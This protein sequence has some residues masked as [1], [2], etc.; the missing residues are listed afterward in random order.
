MGVAAEYPIA[1]GIVKTVT[2]NV[3]TFVQ[4]RIAGNISVTSKSL[5]LK[6]GMHDED[7]SIP[8]PYQP[9]QTLVLFHLSPSLRYLV[10]EMYGADGLPIA[11][12][13]LGSANPLC[14]V[15]FDGIV[16]QSPALECTLSPVW[17]HTFYLPV[18]MPDDRIQDNDE[19]LAAEMKS[20]GFLEIEVWHM[21]SVPTEFLG[22]DKI[23]LHQIRRYGE[24]AEKALCQS[25]VFTAQ[26]LNAEGD[27]EEAEVDMGIHPK[28]VEKRKTKVFEAK[29]R[30]LEGSWLQSVTKATISFQCYFLDDFKDTFVY[31]EQD[32]TKTGADCFNSCYKKW[33]NL[34][35]QFI[36]AYSDWFPDTLKTRRFLCNYQDASGDSLP[37]PTLISPL[38]LP[39]SLATPNRVAHWI[40]CTEFSV[41]PRQRSCAEIGTWQRPQDVLALRRGSVQ[42]HAVLLCCALSGLGKNA[43]VC[44]GTVQKGKEHAWVMT[45]EQGGTVTFWETTTGAKYHLAKRWI[46]DPNHK[47]ECKA[48]VEKRWKARNTNPKWKEKGTLDIRSK[49]SRSEHLQ[50]MNELTTLPISPWKELYQEG[51]VVVVPYETIEVVFNGFQ[52]YGNLG[53]HHPSCIYY[54]MEDDHRSWQRLISEE[55]MPAIMAGQGV[56]LPVGPT[57][58]K[59]TVES[60]QD[61]IEVEIKESIKMIR[62]RQGYEQGFD[63]DL[64]LQESLE[65]YLV[66]LESE[67]TLE[68][69][70]VYGSDKKAKKPWG[71]PSPFNST[72]YVEQCETQWKQ[73]WEQRKAM[74]EAREFLPVKENYVLSGL[75][76]HFSSS[77]L[78]EIRKNLL[79]CKPLM[80]YFSLGTDDAIF[81]TCVKVFPMPSM[82]TSV[83]VFVGVQVPLPPETVL[84]L[85]QQEKEDFMRGE[86]HP[87]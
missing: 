27:A 55:Q 29:R 60:M 33:E 25:K 59:F 35:P 49:M 42:D 85:A 86:D 18:R 78:K 38:A 79:S 52:L 67:C 40:K 22:C 83:W 48:Q 53:N 71:S 32:D 43:F 28:L 63:E 70:W 46:G 3:N 65:Q 66:F 2:D 6:D 8:P 19:L 50:T 84:E 56:A 44:K 16:Q 14:R 73:Y 82:V 11:D 64:G 26:K 5:L 15:K 7:S 24:E 9:T 87:G 45:R 58:S 34:W 21:D 57:M 36:E 13:D 20:K 74:D 39:A 23:D 51:T 80:E 1:Q 76:L 77:D 61:N 47:D 10:V 69:D 4:G 17:N 54:D 30:K 62:M 68:A 41:P 75:P 81:F 72:A 37:L 12:Q 31:P